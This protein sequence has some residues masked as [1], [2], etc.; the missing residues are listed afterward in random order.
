MCLS[1]PFAAISLAVV[2]V[3]IVVVVDDDDDDVVVVDVFAFWLIAMLFEIVL[4]WDLLFAAIW[5]IL[6]RI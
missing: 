5:N 6:L 2:V 4:E 3:V 1:F